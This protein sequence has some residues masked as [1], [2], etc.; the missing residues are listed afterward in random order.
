MQ[1]CAGNFSI[2]DST[3]ITYRIFFI[4][5]KY[6]QKGRF[7]SPTEIK[8]AKNEVQKNWI[9]STELQ[10]FAYQLKNNYQQSGEKWRKVDF[11]ILFYKIIY[12]I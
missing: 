4:P 6:S 7:F 3:R 2:K 9:Q 8:R 1:P 12:R 10:V 5:Q 11:L